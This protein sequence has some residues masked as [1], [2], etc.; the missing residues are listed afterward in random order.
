[1]QQVVLNI[2]DNDIEK[3]LCGI[4][5]EEGKDVQEVIIS[6]IQYFIRQKSSVFKKSDPFSHSVQIKYP[7][8]QDLNDVKPF[9]SVKDSAKYGK[10]LRGKL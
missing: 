4:A 7:V 3:K 1:M 9:S 10:E 6:A 2:D 5:Q 8:L